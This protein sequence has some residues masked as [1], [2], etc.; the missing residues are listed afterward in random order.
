MKYIVTET[1]DK[2]REIFVFSRKINHDCMAESVSAIKNHSYSPWRRI[3]REVVSAGFI[4]GGKCV[5]K[6]E[7]LNLK[8]DPRDTELLHEG[9]KH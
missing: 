4:E 6:S 5:G 1:E 2:I 9:Y 8:S 3:R 7:S